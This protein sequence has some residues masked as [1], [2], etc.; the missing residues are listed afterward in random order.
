MLTQDCLNTWTTHFACKISTRATEYYRELNIG[1]NC[2]SK[3]LFQLELAVA[4]ID[5]ICD[6]EVEDLGCVEEEQV[7]KIIDN[8][9]ILLKSKTCNCK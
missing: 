9:K 6:L 7:C 3:S 4:L 5:Q 1:S 2:A 8:L